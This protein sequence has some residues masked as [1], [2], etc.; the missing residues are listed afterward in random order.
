M[1]L[2]M[3]FTECVDMQSFVFDTI[4]YFLHSKYT[5]LQRLSFCPTLSSVS[6]NCFKKEIK[7]IREG[8]RAMGEMEAGEACILSIDRCC[9]EG[10]VFSACE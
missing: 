1:V 5:P 10:K 9:K 6:K 3:L 2:K 4:N 7:H 8:M